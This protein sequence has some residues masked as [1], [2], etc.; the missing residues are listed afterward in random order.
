MRVITY[1]DADMI[2]YFVDNYGDAT[3]WVDW[4]KKKDAIRKEWPEVYAAIEAKII[5]DRTLHAVVR[6]MRNNMPTTPSGE[7]SEG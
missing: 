7:G 3:R 4:D 6:N 2:H 5:A 1:E